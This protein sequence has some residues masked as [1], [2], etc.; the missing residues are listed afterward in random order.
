MPTPDW[1]SKLIDR[2][3][4]Q[5]VRLSEFQI[6]QLHRHYDLLLR[7]NRRMNLTTVKPGPEIVIRHYCE[8]LFF[9]AHL[10]TESEKITVLDLGSGAP[11]NGG[12]PEFFSENIASLSFTLKGVSS[13]KIVIH[14]AADRQ[15]Q[16]VVYAWAQ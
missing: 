6:A 5:W 14:D 8:S 15:T 11:Q 2:E 7:W 3:S 9:A 10:P 16:T 4:S 12:R 1:F 13:E